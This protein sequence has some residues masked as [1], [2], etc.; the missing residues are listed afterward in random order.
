MPEN[1][2]CKNFF[3]VQRILGNK[4]QVLTSID[5]YI[6]RYVFIDEKFA[7]IYYQI[8]EI[9][10][11]YLIKP[12]VIQRFDIKITQPVIYI[13]YLTFFMENYTKSLAPLLITKLSYHPMIFDHLQMKKYRILF[14]IR[15]NFIAFQRKYFI[16]F[17][18]F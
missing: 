16:Y 14:N 4:I 12:N 5:I 13:N 18:V 3:I 6:P 11:Q 9:K 1:L 10:P 17:G 2:F 8:R 15:N 7:E